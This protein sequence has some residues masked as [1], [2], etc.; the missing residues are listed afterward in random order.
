M[1]AKIQDPQRQR[2][3]DDQ[4]LETAVAYLLRGGVLVSAAIVVLGGSIYL[5]RNGWSTPRYQ[6]FRGEPSDLCSVV[7]ILTDAAAGRGR[8]IIQLGF[9]ALIATP[10]M[11]VMVSLV[12]FL[13]QRDRLYAAVSLIVL[14]FLTYAL[15]GGWL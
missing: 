9:L 12:A 14:L 8:G 3:V 13:L 2:G 11:R 4:R 7:G 15:L 6:V 1:D 10:V 5:A